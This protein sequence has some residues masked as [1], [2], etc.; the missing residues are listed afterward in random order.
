[1]NIV[2]IIPARKGSKGIKNK[3]IITYKGKPLLYHSIKSAL[4]L[5]KINKV[6]VSTN[7]KK[8]ESLAKKFGAEVIIRPNNISKDNSFDKDYLVH[9]YN[10]LKKKNNYIVDLFVLLRPTCPDRDSNDLKKALEIAIKN[11]SKYSSV[12]SVHSVHNP[13]QK[14]FKIK[15]MYLSGFFNNTLAGEYHSLPRQTYDLTYSPNSFFDVL[16]PKYF[17][18]FKSKKKL[19]GNKIFPFITSFY[20][21]IDEVADL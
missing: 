18:K 7:S 4:K 16:K 5:S 11:F 17:M 20:K 14:V 1:M 15:N 21:D 9:A 19:W 3:N 6:I 13:P 10:Y 2:A 12:R 8:Y